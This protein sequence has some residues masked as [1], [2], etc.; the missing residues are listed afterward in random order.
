MD[1]MTPDFSI[2]QPPKITDDQLKAAHDSCDYCPILFE[3]YKFS[4]ELCN[5]FSRLRP[6]SDALKNIDPLYYAVLIGLLNRCSRLMLSNIVLSYKRMH[7]ET[8]AILDRCIF[9]STI[10]INWLCN[11]NFKERFDQLLAD[12]LRTELRLKQKINK[13]IEIREKKSFL[14]EQRMLTSIERYISSSKLTEEQISSSKKLPSLDKMMDDK[15][16]DLQY[17]VAQKIGSHHVHGTWPSLL[18]HYLE[19]DDSGLYSPRDDANETHVNQYVII[20]L[21][22]L[23]AMESF[24]RFMFSKEEDMKPFLNLLT[25]TKNE[26]LKINKKVIGNDFELL[27]DV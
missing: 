25:S 20:P 22:V 17:I 12:G 5:F 18:L 14:I 26:I 2:P 1:N 9:E 19:L 8:T 23:Q 3:W 15:A 24:T 6:D 13:N 7:G 10:K 21:Y 16:D 11:E 4:G 27:K